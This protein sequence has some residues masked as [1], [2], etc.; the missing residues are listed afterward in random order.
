MPFGFLVTFNFIFSSYASYKG[1]FSICLIP[2]SIV[3]FNI[4]LFKLQLTNTLLL[5]I[6]L[7]TWESSFDS[8]VS[9]GLSQLP[10]K[11]TLRLDRN[12]LGCKSS[13]V[14]FSLDDIPVESSTELNCMLLSWLLCFCLR[15]LRSWFMSIFLFNSR[16]LIWSLELIIWISFSSN[17]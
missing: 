6:F 16:W 7:W 4:L 13:R 15:I 1:T 10:Q 3:W 9:T 8:V 14:V 17:S 11:S 12:P 2:K 5:F